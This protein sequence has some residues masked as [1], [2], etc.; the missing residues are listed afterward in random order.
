MKATEIS[1]DFKV[2]KLPKI[3]LGNPKNRGKRKK[4][5]K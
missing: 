1:E 3:P 4:K 5:D 2:K